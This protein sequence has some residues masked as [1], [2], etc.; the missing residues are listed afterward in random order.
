MKLENTTSVYGH[1]FSLN[2]SVKSGMDWT[3][4]KPAYTHFCLIQ[5]GDDKAQA[6]G[7]A[8]VIKSLMAAGGV[9]K[10]TLQATPKVASYSE[11]L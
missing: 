1:T 5:L 3:G 6:E 7:K 9:Y 10:F 8:A 2:V 4:E 11:E